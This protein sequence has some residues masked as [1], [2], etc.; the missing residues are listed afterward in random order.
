VRRRALKEGRVLFCR[1][2]DT[3]YDLALGTAKAFE[4]FRPL[5]NL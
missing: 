2:E 3:L 4:D 1:D 5:Y